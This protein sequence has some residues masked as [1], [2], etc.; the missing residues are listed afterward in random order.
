MVYFG[1]IQNLG[2]YG[3]TIAARNPVNI[4]KGKIICI[5]MLSQN[6]IEVKYAE[7]AYMDESS[8]GAKFVYI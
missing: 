1:T 4:S 7:V 5:S 6:Q 8:F 2:N 3:V